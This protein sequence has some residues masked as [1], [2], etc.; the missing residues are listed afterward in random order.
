MPSHSER[1]GSGI[2]PASLRSART[3]RAI[4]DAAGKIFT[5]ADINSVKVEEIAEAAG[6]SVGTLYKHFTNK[7][8]ILLAFV[9]EGMDVVEAYMAE[10]R[11]QPRALDRV[12]AAG[13]AYVRFAIE[14]PHAM[15]FAA[16]R[17]LQPDQSP[18]LAEINQGLSAR[19]QKLV[20]G[21]ATD[22]KEAMR[23][24]QTPTAPIDEMMLF[25]WALWNGMTTLMIRQDGTAIP[26]EAAQRSLEL[27]REVM[28]RAANYTLE[29]GGSPTITAPPH[30]VAEPE[31]DEPLRATG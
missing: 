6:V 12:Y 2:S 23:E 10:A 25:L 21:I 28:R 31:A 7:Q 1:A 9:S 30:P 26:P 29:G 18:E 15:R 27:A 8:G 16:V 3:R 5:N 19:T 17:V 20:L 14:R 11:Q 24:G 22:L 13:D 4:L